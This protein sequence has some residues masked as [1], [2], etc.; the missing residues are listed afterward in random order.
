MDKIKELHDVC[1]QIINLYTEL[2]ISDIYETSGYMNTVMIK[3]LKKSI[4]E[5][6]NI[7]RT[8]TLEEIKLYLKEPH[9]ENETEIRLVNKLINH[10]EILHG[11]YLTGD[12]LSLRGISGDM[13]ISIYDVVLSKLNVDL[14]KELKRKIYNLNVCEHSDEVF[15]GLL[16]KALKE[17]RLSLLY[18]TSLSEMLILEHNNDI[19]KMPNIDL[20]IVGNAIST[21]SID[22]LGRVSETVIDKYIMDVLKKI[23]N[24]SNMRN[25]YIDVFTYLVTITQVEMLLDYMDRELLDMFYYYCDININSSNRTS[26]EYVKRLIRNRINN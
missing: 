6:N 18:E 9:S 14:I 3:E 23:A 2:I 10:K 26:M 24:T 19:D 12:I 25:N 4:E 16:K 13:K 7:L 5:E 20:T 15:I 21:L 1:Q 22:T 8:I 11:R 17:S